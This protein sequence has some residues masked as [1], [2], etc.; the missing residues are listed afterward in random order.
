[1][2]NKTTPIEN[3]FEKA[4]DYTKTS[5]ELLKLNAIDKSADF[6]S[7]IAARVILFTGVALFFLIGNIG[8]ALWVG[9]ILEK[10]YYG[11]FAVAAFYALLSIVLYVFR[12]QW[13]KIPVSNSVITQ[14]L[15]KKVI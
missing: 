10:T 4:E 12:E 15:K 7:F 6:V 9:E 3:L 5:I 11:F 14:L 1:M 2:E 13:I 8:I